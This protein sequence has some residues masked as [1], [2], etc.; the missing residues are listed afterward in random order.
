[1]KRR[2]EGVTVPPHGEANGLMGCC[3]FHHRHTFD[4]DVD[5]V[6]HGAELIPGGAA[7][8]PSV[9]LW[10]VH[11]AKG[12]LVVQEGCALGW[13]IAAHFGPGDFRSG[14]GIKAREN[15]R[16]KEWL[17]HSSTW[18]LEAFRTKEM[19]DSFTYSASAIHSISSTCP[20]STVLELE[21][22]DGM[23]KDGFLSSAG[24]S[25]VTH[26]FTMKLL[27]TPLHKPIAVKIQAWAR[28]FTVSVIL[29]NLSSTMALQC[30][31]TK[32]LHYRP[33][34]IFIFNGQT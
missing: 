18:A 8:I 1:M 16:D 23:R 32:P 2:E 29:W 13:E 14:P 24:S 31:G 33:T 22:P 30:M 12:P 5:G 4:R 26:R 11:N 15:G 3:T 28:P 10:H 34:F 9:W 6:V 17:W 19:A 7:V 27:P 25:T 20:L 21:G